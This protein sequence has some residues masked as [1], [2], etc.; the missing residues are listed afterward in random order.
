MFAVLIQIFSWLLGA[1]LLAATLLAVW[2]SKRRLDS[3]L[4]QFRAEQE[5]QRNAPGAINPYALLAELYQEHPPETEPARRSRKR[6][7]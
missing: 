3:R 4:R 2:R 7:R 1:A 6:P 5:A